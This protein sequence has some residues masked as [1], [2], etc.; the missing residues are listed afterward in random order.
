MTTDNFEV[1][2]SGA[3]LEIDGDI[4]K[5]KSG[6]LIIHRTKLWF[7]GGGYETRVIGKDIEINEVEDGK[8]RL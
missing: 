2:L 8:I 6:E 3:M 1:D 4:M 7:N 5:V